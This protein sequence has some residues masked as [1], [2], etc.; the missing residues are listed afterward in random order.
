MAQIS[1]ASS[2]SMPV[3]RSFSSFA[4][5]LVKV[6]AMMLQGTAGS[7]AHR[8]S[9]RRWS[10]SGESGVICSRNSTSSSVMISGIQSTEGSLPA[11]KRIRF[12]I[13]WIST[14]VLPLPAPA[15]KRSGPSVVMAASRC[16]SFSFENCSAI[17]FRRARKKRSTN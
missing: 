13:R 6:I 17:Y 10:E 11:P 8:N 4:A 7:T 15:S 1:C 12:A 2:P 14:V 16:I 9:A 3:R 5:L